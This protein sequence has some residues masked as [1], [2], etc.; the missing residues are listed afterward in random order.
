MRRGNRQSRHSA[1]FA[2]F[3]EM[4]ADRTLKPITKQILGVLAMKQGNEVELD[5][6]RVVRAKASHSEIAELTGHHKV[7]IYKQLKVADRHGWIEVYERGDG[8]GNKSAYVFTYPEK[9]SQVT[10]ERSATS[11][12]KGKP[13]DCRK[14]SQNFANQQ[15]EPSKNAQ[16]PEVLEGTEGTC[17]AP[18]A[19][20]TRAPR[21]APKKNE[22]SQP[23]PEP[24]RSHRCNVCRD[25][26]IVLLADGTPGHRQVR[27]CHHDHSWHAATPDEIA[28]HADLLEKLNTGAA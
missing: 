14:V 28:E 25:T 6:E 1:K 13:S 26:G 2:W 18:R 20:V 3:Y 19:R 11:L 10:A 16:V 22:N 8:A 5:G 4:N 12:P 23:L 15:V 17:N 7:T 21:A 27:I 24:A 9:V